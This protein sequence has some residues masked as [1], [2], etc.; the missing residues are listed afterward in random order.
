MVASYFECVRARCLIQLHERLTWPT[1]R[2]RD[3]SILS[4]LNPT[5]LVFIRAKAAA[6]ATAVLFSC[7]ECAA[8]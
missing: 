7:Q 3:L 4:V 5:G 8:V 6:A 1:S 2:R